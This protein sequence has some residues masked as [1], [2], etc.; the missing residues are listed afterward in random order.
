[1]NCRNCGALMRFIW[2]RDHFL[3]DYCKTYDFPEEG[4]DSFKIVDE[5]SG[6]HCP[7]CSAE[8]Q[9]ASLLKMRV[10]HC[11]NCRGFLMKQDRFRILVSNLRDGAADPPVI[12]DP[13]DKKDL[14][15]Q[16]R[17]PHCRHVMDTHAYGGP[18]NV[19]VDNCP[20][21]TVIWLDYGELKKIRDAPG[22]DRRVHPA[23]E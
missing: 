13:V 11:A 4:Q 5:R 19:V 18:G 7:A 2:D 3:C 17:C 23:H 20:R 12:P 10:L 9:V 22:R 8:L 15:R 21:C 6:L 16:V 14:L 1:M